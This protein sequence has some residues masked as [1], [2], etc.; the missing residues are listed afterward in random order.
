M[1][2]LIH[3]HNADCIEFDSGDGE[4]TYDTFVC[5]IS[6]DELGTKFEFDELDP[7]EVEC[8]HDDATEDIEGT[9]VCWKC[10]EVFNDELLEQKA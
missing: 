5:K 1:G 10:G 3:Y 7:V 2:K 6:G 4:S 9:Y 8:D